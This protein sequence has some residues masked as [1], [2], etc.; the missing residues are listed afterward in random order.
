MSLTGKP[1]RLGKG[2]L[3]RRACQEAAR[4]R[5]SLA[6]AAA[7]VR[8]RAGLLQGWRLLRVGADGW[9][10]LLALAEHS[11]ESLCSVGA[12]LNLVLSCLVSGLA[13]C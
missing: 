2:G 12:Q 8:R 7:Q 10:L 5:A 3:E 13:L 11:R 9:T 4:C 6:L 1:G